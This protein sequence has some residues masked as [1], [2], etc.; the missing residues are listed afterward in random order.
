MGEFVKVGTVGEFREGRGRAIVLDGAPVAVFRTPSGFVAIAD[1]CP[2]MGASLADGRLEGD[3]V[4]C[5]WH[6]WRFDVR[7]G[8]S[9][10]REWACVRVYEVRVEGD[11]VLIRRP[12]PPPPRE[13]PPDEPWEVF[14]PDKH[15]KK[16]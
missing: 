11:D 12:D 13:E 6:E 5:A 15:W 7:S 8:K 14:D 1:T 10:M 16:R 9:T 3:Q 2:H 4:E